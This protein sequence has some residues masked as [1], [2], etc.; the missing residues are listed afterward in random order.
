MPKGL[1]RHTRMVMV[2]NLTLSEDHRRIG[3]V[4]K[5]CVWVVQIE[6]NMQIYGKGDQHGWRLEDVL[7]RLRQAGLTVRRDKGKL[8][9]VE[10]GWFGN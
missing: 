3:K 5:G 2:N 10:T 1:Y 6:D 9:K 8:G 7:R 4:L